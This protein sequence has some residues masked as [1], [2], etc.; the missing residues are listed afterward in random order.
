MI[1]NAFVMFAT[2][3]DRPGIVDR[4]TGL[5]YDAGCNLEDSRMAILGEDFALIILVTGRSEDLATL[6]GKIPL[7]ARELDLTVQ[8]KETHAGPGARGGA[9]PHIRYS[10]HA[11]A[12]DHPGIVHR[13]THV[14]SQNRVNISRLDTFLSNAPVTGTPVFALQIEAEVPTSVS[15]ATLKAQ[16]QEVAESEN[17]DLEMHAAG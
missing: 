14:L 15:V 13:V 17:I 6:R 8:V 5:I 9:E 2:G 1:Q 3:R 12:M 7:V 11:V 16:L 10:I 4:I